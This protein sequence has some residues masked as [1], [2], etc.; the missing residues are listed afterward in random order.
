MLTYIKMC[1]YIVIIVALL[2]SLQVK[3]NQLQVDPYPSTRPLLKLLSQGGPDGTLFDD[4]EYNGDS[5]V[6]INSIAIGSL[7]QVDYMQ[8]SYLLL[9]GSLYTAPEHGDGIF[10]PDT[11]TLDENEYL[12][13]LKGKTNGE[14]VNQ[15]TFYTYNPQTGERRVYGPYGT[16]KLN[17]T[18]DFIREGHIVGFHGSVGK[19]ILSNIGVYML[20]PV[21]KSPAFGYMSRGSNF[22]DDP[23]G[24]FPPAVRISRLYIHHGLK[25]DAI[26][27]DYQLLDGSI[28]YGPKH[29]GSGGNLTLLTFEHTSGEHII[30]MKGMIYNGTYRKLA[31]ISF[32]T[33]DKYGS[34]K[35]YGPFGDSGD[36]SFSFSGNIVGL[37]GAIFNNGVREVHNIVEAIQVYFY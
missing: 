32:V 35:T 36:D 20:A 12:E 6:K 29:G 14:C 22:S 31:Q 19:T 26:Q 15:L 2:L 10:T 34:V 21:Q 27:A 23:D 3:C 25:L 1:Y 8:V 7:Y 13:K 33:M 16:T 9:D 18:Q 17:A 4:L 37:A 30:G 28:R 5:V 24:S 11:I